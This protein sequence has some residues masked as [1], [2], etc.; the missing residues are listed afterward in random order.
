MHAYISFVF[1]I[2]FE[3]TKHETIVKM[4]WMYRSA[5]TTYTYKY[6]KMNH[7]RNHCML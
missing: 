1:A 7:E 6:D 3:K 5:R 2:I 4:G